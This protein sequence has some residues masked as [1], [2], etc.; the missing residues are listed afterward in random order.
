[1]PILGTL[2]HFHLRG[3]PPAPVVLGGLV[4]LIEIRT[5]PKKTG[6]SMVPTGTTKAT[7]TET[8]KNNDLIDRGTC[9]FVGTYS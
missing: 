9:I 8:D 4:S 3:A 1:M 2:Q 6:L 7:K 5:W